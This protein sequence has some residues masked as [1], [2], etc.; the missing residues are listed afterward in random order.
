VSVSRTINIVNSQDI[1][2]EGWGEECLL[3]GGVADLQSGTYD[4]VGEVMTAFRASGM[5]RDKVEAAKKVVTEAST[6]A[7]ASDEAIKRLGE[8][9]SQLAR[10]IEN[11][12]HR[13]I[14][15]EL[16]LTAILAIY[17][18]WT[19]QKSDADAQAALAEARTQTEVAQKML[20]ES[21][22]QTASLR[23]LTTKPVSQPQGQGQTTA[24]R[25]RAERRKAE[26][27]AKREKKPPK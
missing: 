20:E 12:G 1:T 6:G 4:F 15:W 18:I 25:N 19:D 17:T 16:I 23:E 13:R 8:I 21:Q 10:L 22:A 27:L 7:I 11:S 9:S 26:A 2:I 5:T 14:N 3:C 24:P